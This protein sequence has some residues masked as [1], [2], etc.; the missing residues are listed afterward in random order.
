MRSSRRAN[1]LS[2]KKCSKSG[3]I[4]KYK[5]CKIWKMVKRLGFKKCSGLRK[6]KLCRIAK[7]IMGVSFIMLMILVI[8]LII[9]KNKSTARLI[10]LLNNPAYTGLKTMYE[11]I[12]KTNKYNDRKIY[13]V[14]VEK[15]RKNSDCDDDKL[16]KYIRRVHNITRCII[17]I[18]IPTFMISVYLLGF[19]YL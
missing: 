14:L 19:S 4:R 1:K 15:C 6:H 18:Y 5:L 9:Y 3:G 12:K 7:C 17:F 13:N 11:D 2:V 10:E 16:Q 8:L